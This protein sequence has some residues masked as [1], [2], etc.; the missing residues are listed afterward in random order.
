MSI[1]LVTVAQIKLLTTR[2]GYGFSSFGA[3]S[4]ILSPFLTNLQNVGSHGNIN[5]P[6]GT[7]DKSRDE[8]DHRVEDVLRDVGL[9]DE[10][11]SG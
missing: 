2:N 4:K 1:H 5:S 8:I 3:L 7:R 10:V 11:K 9:W 6:P